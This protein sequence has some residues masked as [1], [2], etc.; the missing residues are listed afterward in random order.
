MRAWHPLLVL[1]MA[2]AAAG[3]AQEARLTVLYT[4]DV[5]AHVLP[6]DDVRERPARGSLA[7][8]ATLV[9]RVRAENPRTVVLD[10]GDA[11]Q[12]TPLAHYALIGA[13]ADGQDPTI[14]AM[15]L[16]GYDAAVIGNHEFNYGLDVL[17]R[18]LGQ[19]RF[20]WLAANI[21]GF[22]EARLPLREELVVARG[23]I[24][25]G[26]IGLTSPNVPHW[27]P[28]AHWQG[29]TF[30]DPVALAAERVRALRPRVDVLVVVLHGG[31]ERDFATGA[32]N[33]TE[34]ENH[35]WRLAQLDGIDLL[36][37]G[38]THRDIAPRQLGRT[39]V[40][41]PGRW[42][43]LVTRFDLTLARKGRRW[44]VVATSGA[45][46][47]VDGELADAA[48][49]ASVHGAHERT[50]AELARPLGELTVPLALSSLPMGDDAALDLIHAVQLEATAAQLSLA[51]PLSGRPP[52]PPGPLTPRHAHALYPYP[53][54]LLV[55]KVTGVQLR[56]VLEHA[57]RGW[58]ALECGGSAAG[59][60]LRREPGLP[61]YSY[62]TVE[63][64]TYF[65]DP[66]APAGARVRGLRVAGLPVTPGGE[67]TL[68]INSY[69]GAGGGRYP[70]LASAPRVREID[71]PMVELMVEY[72]AAHPILTPLP[73]ENWS[74]TVPLRD[75]GSGAA[76]SVY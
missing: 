71:R 35:G 37:T 24:T 40:A 25:I 5:H 60:A 54:T 45:N 3:A 7:Q 66:T 12:G 17:R 62:D 61:S 32:A 53:N 9:A 26:V 34:F 14:A 1:V 46:L 15:N 64:A 18:S 27:D 30:S 4:S 31:F 21:G 39:W 56:D 59:G 76:A 68:A 48:V 74:F 33:D 23:G 22:R 67:Y 11:I 49:V 42:A 65:V 6:F 63:G 57:V 69:R 52:F 58:S 43:E 73:T 41:Q 38:H 16:V 51:A 19:S 55:V 10:G 20:P 72:F 75:G 50:V 70:H 47:K 28:Q 13:G 8:V 2:A 44:S 29:L 36:L